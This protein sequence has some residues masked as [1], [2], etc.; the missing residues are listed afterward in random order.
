MESYLSVVVR[1]RQDATV[2]AVSGEL[3]LASSPQLLQAL[4]GT[5]SEARERLVLDLAGL[6]FMDVTGLRALLRVQ[7]GARQAGRELILAN[8]QPGIRRLLT[9]TSTT[10]LLDNIE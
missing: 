5:Y 6:Q 1:D 7:E 3:D 2:L 8:V 9:V 10:E 4:E